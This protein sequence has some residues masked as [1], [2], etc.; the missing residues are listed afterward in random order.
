MLS[1]QCEEHLYGLGS[2][3]PKETLR[4]CMVYM[5]LENERRHVIENPGDLT[6]EDFREIVSKIRDG[7]IETVP[8]PP[9]TPSESQSDS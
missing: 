8:L 3:I 6:K 5:D 9:S 1:L 4:P 7:T 2:Y